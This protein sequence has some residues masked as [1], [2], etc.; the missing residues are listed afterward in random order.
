MVGIAGSVPPWL[1]D[2]TDVLAWIVIG[3]FTLGAVLE[4]SARRQDRSAPSRSP[5][6]AIGAG[7]KRLEYA[8]TVATGAWG[9]F[10]LFWLLLF[11]HF[12]FVH[13][14]YVEGILALIAVPACLYAGYLLWEGRDTLF[15]LSRSSAIMGLIYLPFETIPAVQL[16]SLR[17]PSP[18]G[19]LIETVTTQTGFLMSLLGYNPELIPG[20]Q[21][22]QN[23]Y[24][25]VAAD[26]QI[27]Q[28]SIVLACTGLG[29]IAIFAGLIGAVRAPLRRKLRA[30]GVAVP[31]IYGLNLLRTTFIGITFGEQL[32]QIFP[33]LVL[34][35]F[36][37][38]DPYRVSWYVSDRIISQLLAVI[39]LVGVTYLVVRELPEILT[40]IEDVL[41]M[42]T[43]DE[44]DLSDAL[45]LPQGQK[46][47]QVPEQSD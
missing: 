19:V 3:A 35:L 14:S 7:R 23:T 17:I 46:E 9:L 24:E 16:G 25:F 38:T 4:L 47:R 5:E 6:S 28:F 44:Y 40:V 34:A 31:I 27:L 18:R 10:A 26:G 43:G 1:L 12:A 37:G 20:P 42:A 39:A 32:L 41:F 13:K 8:R 36:G 45:D 2:V 30:L 29:S 22:F 11:P 33:N 15:V 21:G